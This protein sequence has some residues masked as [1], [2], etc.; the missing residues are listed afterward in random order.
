MFGDARLGRPYSRV[1]KARLNDVIDGFEGDG[2]TRA[3]GAGAPAQRYVANVPVQ[4]VLPE[5]A[6]LLRPLE[7]RIS[8]ELGGVLG[9]TIPGTP[10]LYL[11]A[12]GQRTPLHFDPTENLTVVLQGTKRFRLF[13]PLASPLLRPI[14]GPMAAFACW[15]H[16]VVPAVYSDVDAWALA[17]GID[18]SPAFADLVLG[19][20]EAL[21]LPPGWWHAVSGSQEPNV[22]VV[23]GFAPSEEK[24]A[25]YFT[26]WRLPFL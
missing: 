9:P 17:G 23:F 22:T 26:P 8:K 19:P 18:C 15:A 5:F 4:S 6:R 21:Y 24:G 25:R 16:G 2:E 7:R 14:G 3:A 1:G 11:G 10:V 12:H 20:G 13:P